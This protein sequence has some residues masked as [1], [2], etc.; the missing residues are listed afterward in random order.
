MGCEGWMRARATKRQVMVSPLTRARRPPLL[1]PPPAAA[2]R[3][4]VF[5]G[6]TAAGGQR[7]GPIFFND[8]SAPRAHPYV[9]QN[10]FGAGAR[11]FFGA[12]GHPAPP[13]HTA[14]LFGCAPAAARLLSLVPHLRSPPNFMVLVLNLEKQREILHEGPTGR[15]RLC[16]S[17]RRARSCSCSFAC[18]CATTPP[19]APPPQSQHKSAD[20]SRA[21]LLASRI[22][23]C[24]LA[25]STQSIEMKGPP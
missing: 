23:S 16:C 11:S 7:R 13:R 8:P 1:P 3:A 14:P 18:A 17:P 10:D 5:F 6:I 25:T 9:C 20:R 12:C 4:F 2:P 19:P 22:S 15:I 24:A 21:M